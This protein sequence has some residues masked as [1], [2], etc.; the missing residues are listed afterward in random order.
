[1]LSAMWVHRPVHV[2]LCEN[3]SIRPEQHVRLGVYCACKQVLHAAA[4]SLRQ[5]V[6]GAAVVVKQWTNLALVCKRCARA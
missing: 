6:G 5:G 2:T 3:S 4:A 1:M